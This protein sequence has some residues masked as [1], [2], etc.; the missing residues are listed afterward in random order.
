MQLLARKG[1]ASH[2]RDI[3]SISVSNLIYF[4]S[5]LIYIQ[6]DC[7]LM[8]FGKGDKHHLKVGETSS[9]KEEWGQGSVAFFIVTQK[10][11]RRVKQ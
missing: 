1:P 4:V 9:E 7:Q 11:W 6:R 5:R 2:M 3:C 8:M 10:K